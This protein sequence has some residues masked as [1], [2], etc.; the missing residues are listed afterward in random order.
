VSSDYERRTDVTEPRGEERREFVEDLERR[1]AFV[2][3]LLDEI[4]R[5]RQEAEQQG[6]NF[7]APTAE[8]LKKKLANAESPIIVSQV[9]GSAPPGGTF[10]LNIGIDNPDPV[11]WSSL[12]VHVFVGPLNV[13]PDVGDEGHAI[14]PR[15]PRLT[16]PR[17]FGLS[18]APGATQTLSFA[19]TVPSGIARSNYLGN[20]ILFQDRSF[21]VGRYLERSFFVFEVT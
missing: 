2:R 13:A 17:A 11:Q 19:I 6:F 1:T 20:A 4:D 5:Q 18:L 9:W 16:M 14:D 10:N 21:D 12:F 15:F 8:Q 3:D 7:I